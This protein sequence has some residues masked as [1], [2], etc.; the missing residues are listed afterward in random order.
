ME[1]RVESFYESAMEQAEDAIGSQPV[2]V[3]VAAVGLG[4]IAG[5]LLGGAFASR[6]APSMWN[7]SEMGHRVWERLGHLSPSA[8]KS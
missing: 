4:V 3:V 8:W 6:P 2:A 7:P 1:N 5:L